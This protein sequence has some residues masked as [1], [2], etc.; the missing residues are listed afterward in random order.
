MFG[1]DLPFEVIIIAFLILALNPTL[2]SLCKGLIEWLAKATR[3]EILGFKINVLGPLNTLTQTIAHYL[4]ELFAQ[5]EHAPVNLLSAITK[6]FDYITKA[7]FAAA[8]ELQRF[9]TWTV[10]VAIPDAITAARSGLGKTVHDVT[11]IVQT[12]PGK[13]IT[14]LPKAI[15]NDIGAIQWL[16]EH[17]KAVERAVARSGSAAVSL[18]VGKAEGLL[19]SID[20]RIAALTKKLSWVQKIGLTGAAAATVALGVER[21]GL[22]WIKCENNKKVGKAI[23]GLPAK[24]LEGLLSLL[25][26][27]LAFSA[28]CELLPLM[29]K[30]LELVEPEIVEVTTGAAAILCRGRYQAATPLAIPALRLP[31]TP[32]GFP[33]LQLP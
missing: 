14:V 32:A 19:D 33:T 11:K 6:Y 30:G 26:D 23:C 29:E 28:V 2:A 21:L 5:V 17:L 22:N 4:G 8:W 20:R 31:V 9:A 12:L 18:P 3:I 10:H 16:A 27:A 13:T 1:I 24:A 25:T 7:G 15:R